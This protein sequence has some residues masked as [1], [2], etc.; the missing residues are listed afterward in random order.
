M[1]NYFAYYGFEPSLELDEN[2]LRRRY[3]EKSRQ[4]HPDFYG[5]AHPDEQAKALVETAYN[6][7]AFAELKDP[8]RRTACVLRLFGLLDES[9]SPTEPVDLGPDFLVEMMEAGE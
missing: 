9:G 6:N 1:E 2:E 5:T 4:F 7:T 3:L 8:Q